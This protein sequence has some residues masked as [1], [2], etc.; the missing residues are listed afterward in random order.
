MKNILKLIILFCFIFTF[1]VKAISK[2]I[3]LT[4]ISDAHIKADKKENSLTPSI[5]K[6]LKA[7][8]QTNVDSSDYVVFLGDNVQNA[9]RIDIAMFAKIINRLNKPYYAVMGNRD[10][11]KTKGVDKKEYYR[12]INKFSKNKISKL[13]CYKRAD[14]FI[15]IFLSGV[16][17]TFPTYKG[18]YKAY[19]L[20]FLDKT[21]EKFK[22]KKAVIFQHFPVVAPGEDEMRSTYKPE[23]YLETI[24]KHDNVL[25]VVSGHYHSENVIES[26]GIKHI[27]VGALC[28]GGEY[29]QIK[30]YDNND[31][32]YSI[33]ATILS[34]Q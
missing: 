14:D 17:E 11:G 32:T 8:D 23:N 15:F 13:P 18:Y 19:E 10:I 28:D 33:T 30:I 12:I 21:L 31:G 7:I 2:D 9:N 25:A 24:K 29:E 34:V 4:V 16:N 26:D 1:Q 20:E 6:L 27:S 3:T 5:D 22:D